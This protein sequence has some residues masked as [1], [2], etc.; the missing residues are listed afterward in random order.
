MRTTVTL[1]DELVRTAEEFTGITERS[2][3]LRTALRALI[4]REAGHRLIALGGSEPA[5]E[6]PRRRR[7]WDD[8]SD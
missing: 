8:D 6:L 3:L 7:P 5:L 4:E 2:T 1:D